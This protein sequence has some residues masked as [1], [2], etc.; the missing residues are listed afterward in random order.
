MRNEQFDIALFCS[1][2]GVSRAKLFLKIKEWS[3]CTHNEFILYF[4][5]KRTSELLMQ[6][7]INSSQI[8]QEVGFK[9]P[10]Y[11][12]KYFKKKFGLT[13][14]EYSNKFIFS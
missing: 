11:F 9:N 8:S 4:R 14:L 5:M 1:E 13:P 12:S 2:L 7:T 6:R 3:N 10:K